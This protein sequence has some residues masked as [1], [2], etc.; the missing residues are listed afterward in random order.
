MTAPATDPGAIARAEVAVL[1]AL[2]DGARA[3][4]I[5]DLYEAC[6]LDVVTLIVTLAWLTHTGVIEHPGLG[7]YQA[8]AGEAAA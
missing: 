4:T 8:R 1:D 3:H 7:T 5:V 2:G 6:D